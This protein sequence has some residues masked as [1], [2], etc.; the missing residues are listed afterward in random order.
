MDILLA[1]ELSFL[2]VKRSPFV[3]DGTKCHDKIISPIS[4]G[5]EVNNIIKE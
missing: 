1:D 5:Q 3:E 2:I 4:S